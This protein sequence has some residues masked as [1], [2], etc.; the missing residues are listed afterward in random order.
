MDAM[1]TLNKQPRVLSKSRNIT[2]QNDK[3]K[4]MSND[5]D[6]LQEARN[7]AQSEYLASALED[8]D[9]ERDCKKL[10]YEVLDAQLEL[11]RK[12]YQLEQARAKQ[13]TK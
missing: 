2:A 4:M 9:D 6:I 3:L 10:E 13:T 11:I 1:N 12:Q 5:I 7:T 8:D